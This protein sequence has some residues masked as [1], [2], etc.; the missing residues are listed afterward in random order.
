MGVSMFQTVCWQACPLSTEPPLFL[1]QRPGGYGGGDSISVRCIILNEFLVSF[2]ENGFWVANLGL[3]L[4]PLPVLWEGNR[5]A[6]SLL[7]F[8]IFSSREYFIFKSTGTV[9]PGLFIPM[10]HT[11]VRMTDVCLD[12][13]SGYASSDCCEILTHFSPMTGNMFLFCS[14]CNININTWCFYHQ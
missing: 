12:K 7:L 14:V 2:S 6:G 1:C 13:S 3:T 8:S 11:S 10:T 4:G 5:P 9:W